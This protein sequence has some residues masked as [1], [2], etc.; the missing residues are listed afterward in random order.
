[1]LDASKIM[2]HAESKLAA[3]ELHKQLVIFMTNVNFSYNSHNILFKNITQ[4]AALLQK[5]LAECINLSLEVNDVG[6]N[7]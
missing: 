4:D 7:K 3:A 1:M 5:R 6:L 2:L